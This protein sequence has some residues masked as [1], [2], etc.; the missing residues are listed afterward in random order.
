MNTPQESRKVL[1]LGTVSIDVAGETLWLLPQRAGFWPARGMLLV[2]DAHIG[3][4]S[5][6]RSAGVAIPAGTT[7]SDLDRLS[8]LIE[9]LGARRVAF[10]GDLLHS[11]QGRTRRTFEAFRTWRAGHAGIEMVLV[12]GN[13]DRRAGDPPAEWRIVCMDQPVVIGAFALCHDPQPVDGCYALAGHVHPAVRMTGK[14][15]DRTRLPC[16]LLR[17]DH[18]IL[19]AFGG[20][21]GM[22]TL[23]PKSDDRVFVV[24]GDAVVPARRHARGQ[25]AVSAS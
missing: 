18:A 1:P 8:G 22:F 15:R 21:T 13:H 25:S 16:F 20:F 11:Q 12:R 7:H 24:A 23:A 14:G 3:K 5:A 2:A 9:H 10:L 17:P 6:F 4:A 19:P